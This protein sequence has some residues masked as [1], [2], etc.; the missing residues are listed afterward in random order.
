[1]DDSDFLR[2]ERTSYTHEA[3]IRLSDNPD[4]DPRIVECQFRPHHSL[5]TAYRA[6]KKPKTFWLDTEELDRLCRA[7][8]YYQGQFD[9][10][11]ILAT[12]SLLIWIS[13]AQEMFPIPQ[14]TKRFLELLIGKNLPSRAVPADAEP[15]KEDL[16][17]ATERA[18]LS[19]P[20]PEDI[21]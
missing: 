16:D 10:E 13:D 9:N 19:L 14:E 21:S 18:L 6:E 12:H 2:F 1:M 17:I 4:D 5:L 7:W 8:R 11:Q 3:I 20:D 15:T